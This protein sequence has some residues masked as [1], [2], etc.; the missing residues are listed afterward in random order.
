MRALSRQVR[1]IGADV[2]I[3][4]DGVPRGTATLDVAGIK[5]SNAHRDRDLRSARFFDTT[6]HPILK[7]RSVSTR[8]TSL[9]AVVDGLLT[10]RGK[11][12]PLS[13]V[14]TLTPQDDGTIAVHATGTFDRLASPLRKAP[15]WLIGSTVDVVV[16]AVLRPVTAAH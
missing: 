9:G 4:S 8:R 12:C 2:T 11:D 7:F 6:N 13:L 15:R 14:A 1:A 5:T 10:I 16:E 3:D